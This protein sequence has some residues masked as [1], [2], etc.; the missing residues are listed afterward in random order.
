MRYTQR[1]IYNGSDISKEIN[2]FR[3]GTSVIPVTTSQYLYI[4]SEVPF[5][6][7]WIDVAVPNAET[8]ALTPYIWFGNEWVVAVDIDDETKSSGVTLA[9][10]GRLN[11]MTDRLKGWD[12]EQ[13]TEDVSGL[14]SFK[15]Y[16]MYWIRLAVS[17]NLSS[18]TAIK[19]IGQKFSNDADL[20]S[21]YPDL[22]NQN[23]MTAFS[24]G[25]QS[26]EEQ[27]YIAAE[28]IIMDLIARNLIQ[29]RGQ[30]LDWRVFQNPSIHK[31]AEICFGGMGKAYEERKKDAH[32][33]YKEAMNVKNF[34][35]DENKDGKLSGPEKRSST[36]F[37]RR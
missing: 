33:A 31:V 23:L 3:S 18:T 9:Q 13:T 14:T 7:L 20:Y 34:R 2:D 35:L 29:S 8:S 12:I 24:S 5:N 6:N 30:V 28:Q 15:I 16:N 37:L 27:A 32:A 25:K 36:V 17:A 21:L 19:Y 22:Q 26:W 1:V 10:D 4:G 11:F